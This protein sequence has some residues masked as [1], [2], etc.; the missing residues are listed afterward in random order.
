MYVVKTM[1]LAVFV[2]AFSLSPFLSLTNDHPLYTLRISIF[3]IF[4]GGRRVPLSLTFLL[5]S[6][7]HQI[8]YY[9]F[10]SLVFKSFYLKKV[11][12]HKLSSISFMHHHQSNNTRTTLYFFLWALDS[13]HITKLTVTVHKM[14]CKNIICVSA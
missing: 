2:V 4:L 13:I 3:P 11:I 5:V 10:F 9:L 8:A 14:A 6:W 12:L 1:H 7:M